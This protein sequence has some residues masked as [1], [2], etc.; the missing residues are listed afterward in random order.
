VLNKK[1]SAKNFFA[2]CQKKHSANASLPSAK[3]KHSAKQFFKPCFGA[4]NE[5]K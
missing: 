1:Q 4:L 2:E 3:V 5:F